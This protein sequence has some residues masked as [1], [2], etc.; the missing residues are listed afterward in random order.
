MLHYW[1]LDHLDFDI[2]WLTVGSFDGVHLGHQAII[3]HVVKKAHSESTKAAAVTFYPHPGLVLAKR[4][5]AFYLSSPEEKAEQL[6]KLGIDLLVTIPFSLNTAN[7]TAKEFVGQMKHHL[8]FRHLC[9]GGDFALGHNRE[10]NVARLRELGLEFDFLVESFPPYMV[11]NRVVSSSWVREALSTGN[12]EQVCEL[13]DRPYEVEGE[14]IHGDHRGRSLGFPT[15]NLDVWTSKALPRPGIY[16]GWANLDGQII[17]A[18]TNVGFRPTFE[19]QPAHPRVE[20]YL[21]D[22]DENIYHRQLSVS[23]NYRLR[24]EIRFHHVEDLIEQMY[25]D[26]LISRDLLKLV[27]HATVSG[28]SSLYS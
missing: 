6:A 24:D 16:A 3:R 5:G 27:D 11:D 7:L 15:A 9:V 28:P 18:V 17:P 14:V 26:V 12:M 4:N 1:S 2:N 10:G 13:L 23:F 21:L 22:F 20:A 8:G 19:N 25:K